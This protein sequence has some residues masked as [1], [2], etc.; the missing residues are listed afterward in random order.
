MKKGLLTLTFICE[1][2]F[3]I[4]QIV[5]QGFFYL[6]VILYAWEANPSG[7]FVSLIIFLRYAI[8]TLIVFITMRATL[9]LLK[10]KPINIKEK[11]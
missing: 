10:N 7:I 9:K 5:V 8:L 6:L 3:F 11:I 2:L 1:I 4:Y